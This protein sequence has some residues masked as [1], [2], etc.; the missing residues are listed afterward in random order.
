MMNKRGI[1]ILL[2]LLILLMA[3]ATIPSAFRGMMIPGIKV[4]PTATVSIKATATRPLYIHHT[5]V[6]TGVRPTRTPAG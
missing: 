1:V 5:P 4:I 2:A 3:C 6:P